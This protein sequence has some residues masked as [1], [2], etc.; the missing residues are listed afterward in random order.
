MT[1]FW[2]ILRR[3]TPRTDPFTMANAVVFWTRALAPAE[4]GYEPF[5][6]EALTSFALSIDGQGDIVA[7]GAGHLTVKE[8]FDL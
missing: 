2:L 7:E 4:D 5:A 8:V 3:P 6:T 1:S